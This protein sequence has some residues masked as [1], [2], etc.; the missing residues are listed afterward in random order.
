[1]NILVID[2]G[3]SHIK[4]LATGETEPRK[5]DS[6]ASMTPER[7]VTEVQAITSDWAFDVITIGLPGAVGAHGPRLEPGKLGTGWVGFPFEAAFGRP[8][9]VVNDA[10]MQALGAY[11]GG[12]MLFLGLGT[13]VGS[14]LISD[15]VAVYMDLGNLPW[16][17]G[18]S[19]GERLGREGL[20]EVGE[21]E[22]QRAVTYAVDTLRHA[23]V[24][25]YVVLGGGN[26]KRIAS[27]PHDTR[28]GD[29]H[30]AFLGGFRLWEEFVEPLDRSPG[31]AWRVL[32]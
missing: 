17:G 24:A 13:G 10:V 22:W 16:R 27:L 14:A 32:R 18:R 31:S 5:F 12:R 7:L 21:E 8:V 28:I 11:E 25:D 26:A 19:L 1:M 15:H 29:N 20:E 30:D 23:F 3:G 2:V 9:R 4:M 6:D